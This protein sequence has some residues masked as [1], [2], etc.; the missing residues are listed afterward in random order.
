MLLRLDLRLCLLTLFGELYLTVEL[1]Q[2]G[3][4]G[5]LFEQCKLIRVGNRTDKVR[6]VV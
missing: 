2:E 1:I 3:K 4:V 5:Q 6:H